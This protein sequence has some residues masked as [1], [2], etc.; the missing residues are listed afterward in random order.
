MQYTL[1][2]H[3]HD[4]HLSHSSSLLV[5]LAYKLMKV[6]IWV[7]FQR[8]RYVEAYAIHKRLCDLEEMWMEKCIDGSKLIRVRSTAEQRNRI[9]VIE[10]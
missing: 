7:C 5:P 4:F 8:C 9:I 3:L 2:L 10:S 6:G 1:I